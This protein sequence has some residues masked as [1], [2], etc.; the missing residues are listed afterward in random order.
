MTT[1]TVK[2]RRYIFELTTYTFEGLHK[3][4]FP[5]SRMSSVGHMHM[6]RGGPCAAVFLSKMAGAHRD[7]RETLR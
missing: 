4:R 1:Y 7:A 5:V 3:E 2:V 6:S